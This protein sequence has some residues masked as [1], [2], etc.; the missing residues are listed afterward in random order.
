METTPGGVEAQPLGGPRREKRAGARGLVLPG[1]LLASLLFLEVVLRVQTGLPVIS[2]GLV[3]AALFAGVIALV[4][5]LVAS[6]FPRVARDVVVAVCLAFISVLYM[7]QLIYYDIFTTFYTVFSA[8]NAGQVAEF[9]GDILGKLGAHAGWLLLMAVPLVVFLV[10]RVRARARPR[11]T[12]R[13]RAVAAGLLVAFFAVA[14]AGI[15]LGDKEQNSAYDMYYREQHPVASVDRLGLMTTMRV[16]LQRNLLGFEREQPP[17]PVVA[18]VPQ[19]PDPATTDAPPGDDEAQTSGDQAEPS[20]PAVVEHNVM[21]IDFEQLLAEAESEELRS[22]HEYFSQR[23]PTAQN[24]HTGLFEGYN[25]IFLTA[26]GYSHL[27][28]D[29]A[30]TPTLHKMTHEGFHFTDLYT[31]LW[32]VSTSDGEYVA[33]TGLIPKSG[34]WSM[35]RSGDNSMPFAMGNQLRGLDYATYAFHNHTYDYYGRDVSH[36]NLGYDYQGVGNG[37]EVARTWPASDLEMIDVT[38]PDVL[39]DE[40]FHAY[41][42]TVSGHLEY[43]FGGNAM[44]IKNRDLVED[45]PYTEAGKAYLATQVELDRALELLLER[46]EEAGVAERTLVVLSSDHYPYGLTREQIEDLEGH[47]V[48]TNFELYRN[49]LLIYAPG[50]EP[51]TVDDPVSSLDIIPT[52]S[53]LMGLDYDSRLLMG[54]DV[55]SDAD[56]LVIFS[57]R[58]FVTDKGRYDSITREFTPAEGQEVPEGYRQAVSDEIDR[59]FYYSAMV[60][61]HDYYRVVLDR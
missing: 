10:S 39:A 3:Y 1:F 40:P 49:S 20:E 26:E 12:W 4:V 32:G 2:M 19:T 27:A 38:T 22:L 61:D 28:V 13:H 11:V 16:D 58:S 42:M 9:T 57:D 41:Y 51:E 54:R 55:F 33:T 59:R 43:N 8:T 31:P 45:L 30:V 23:E 53:N 47:D 50:M 44:A 17:P 48:D 15:N 14:V 24:E 60:L 7:S 29:P 5:H 35:Q 21:D 36:P 6:L 34:V 37:L 52:L 46:L 25:L 56:P 18:P